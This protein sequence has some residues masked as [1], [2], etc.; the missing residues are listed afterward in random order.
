MD[1]PPTLWALNACQAYYH[2]VNKDS[3]GLAVAHQ[4]PGGCWGGR[5][6]IEM[7]Q[8]NRLNKYLPNKHPQKTTDT[9]QAQNQSS[10]SEALKPNQTITEKFP[11]VTTATKASPPENLDTRKQP[12]LGGWNTRNVLPIRLMV[13]SFCGSRDLLPNYALDSVHIFIF[14]ALAIW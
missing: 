8:T 14:V 4:I 1:F 5:R 10:D 2:W 9:A 12:F 11:R 6:A 3:L 7:S 13:T